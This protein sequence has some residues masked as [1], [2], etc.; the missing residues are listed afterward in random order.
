MLHSAHILPLLWVSAR[1]AK[2]GQNLWEYIHRIFEN[3]YV[4]G[5]T[6][7]GWSHGSCSWNIENWE[8]PGFFSEI[9][10][11]QLK[12]I[13]FPFLFSSYVFLCIFPKQVVFGLGKSFPPF[14][15]FSQA[16]FLL[17][18]PVPRFLFLFPLP[19]IWGSVPF[20]L[21]SLLLLLNFSIIVYNIIKCLLNSFTS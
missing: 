10:M 7:P 2:G 12:P 9:N 14:A 15:F 4:W 21:P 19:C 17:Y 18:L 11:M 1:A 3:M 16:V 8:T 5:H 6:S 13:T 20:R